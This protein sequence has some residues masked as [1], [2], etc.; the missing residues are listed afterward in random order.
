MTNNL[1]QQYEKRLYKAFKGVTEIKVNGNIHKVNKLIAHNEMMAKI[2]DEFMS[3][4]FKSNR[5]EL[6]RE[7]RRAKR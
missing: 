3:L 2:E 1:Y 7:N 5:S 6:Q 4:A